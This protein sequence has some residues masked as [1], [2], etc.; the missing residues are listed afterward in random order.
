TKVSFGLADFVTRVQ[1]AQGTRWRAGASRR[2]QYLKEGQPPAG[3][4]PRAAPP[5][6]VPALALF[7]AGALTKRADTAKTSLESVRYHVERF[8][9]PAWRRQ[10]RRVGRALESHR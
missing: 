3:D 10:S 5:A 7:P 2:Q 8:S 4:A 9:T 6:P 1:R